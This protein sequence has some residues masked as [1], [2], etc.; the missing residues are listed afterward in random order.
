MA[1]SSHATVPL[2]ANGRHLLGAHLWLDSGHDERH[3]PRHYLQ[4]EQK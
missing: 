1:K 4:T 2:T 3:H